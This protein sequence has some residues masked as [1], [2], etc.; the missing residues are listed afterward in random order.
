MHLAPYIDTTSAGVREWRTSWMTMSWQRPGSAKVQPTAEYDTFGS[1]AA[2]L[3][4]KQAQAEASAR[5]GGQLSFLPDDII[6]PVADSMGDLLH[7]A[8]WMSFTWGAP[9]EPLSLLAFPPAVAGWRRCP[10]NATCPAP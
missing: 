2:E 6:A 8:T 3:A 10:F 4:R 7:H 9:G 5:A 1:T